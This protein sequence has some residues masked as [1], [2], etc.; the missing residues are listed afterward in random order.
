MTSVSGSPGV[1]AKNVDTKINTRVLT[2]DTIFQYMKYIFGLTPTKPEIHPSHEKYILVRLD[3]VCP[4][5]ACDFQSKEDAFAA[6]GDKTGCCFVMR[7]DHWGFYYRFGT[8]DPV[9]EYLNPHIGNGWQHFFVNVLPVLRNTIAGFEFKPHLP[10]CCLL[11][12][13]VPVELRQIPIGRKLDPEDKKYTSEMETFQKDINIMQGQNAA[14]SD[15]FQG[16]DPDQKLGDFTNLS[17]SLRNF[18]SE[19]AK[20]SNVMGNRWA[21]CCR[22]AYINALLMLRYLE[23]YGLDT[24]DGWTVQSLS[25]L[26]ESILEILDLFG[27]EAM[28]TSAGPEV[29]KLF[30]NFKLL[31]LH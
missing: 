17:D 8:P 4:T 26:C 25:E 27:Y 9:Q 6:L 29:L 13:D 14:G 11:L 3:R 5:L 30:R 22:R 21:A 7:G 1:D 10:D 28:W 12:S 19:M 16:F 2:K 20:F 18:C 31:N 24:I 23:F 15:E